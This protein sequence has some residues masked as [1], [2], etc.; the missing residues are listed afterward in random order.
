MRDYPSQPLA[1]WQTSFP[2]YPTHQNRKLCCL[3]DTCLEV[4]SLH[5]NCKAG[6]IRPSLNALCD[7]LA[8]NTRAL[9]DDTCHLTSLQSCLRFTLTDEGWCCLITQN[10]C[11]RGRGSSGWH[12]HEG[13]PRKADRRVRGDHVWR[14]TE[15]KR[16]MVNVESSACI[17][18]LPGEWLNG[19][20]HA[21]VLVN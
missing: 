10:P 18:L 21:T 13:K 8:E 1:V 17:Q 15:R 16:R 12:L 14:E 9:W 7:V 2:P 19:G 3:F 11:Q 6:R 4:L 20:E 5:L